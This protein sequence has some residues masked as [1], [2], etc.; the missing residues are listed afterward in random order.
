[1]TD[2]DAQTPECGA[3]LAE[4]VAVERR[5]RQAVQDA[6]T[7]SDAVTVAF[8]LGMGLAGRSPDLAPGVRDAF[9]RYCTVEAQAARRWGLPKVRQVIM[10]LHEREKFRT[11]ADWRRSRGVAFGGLIWAR[12]P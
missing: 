6:C 1:M 9:E 8:G 10:E 2:E 11:A 4:Y 12:K 7:A 3:T 5:L